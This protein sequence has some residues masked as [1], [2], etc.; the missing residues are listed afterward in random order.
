MGKRY[1]KDEKDSWGGVKG[2]IVES[3]DGGAMTSEQVTHL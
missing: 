2:T 1:L 3:D